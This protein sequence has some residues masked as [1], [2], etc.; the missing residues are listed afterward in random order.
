MTAF[1]FPSIDSPNRKRLM[2][3][4]DRCTHGERKIKFYV[5]PHLCDKSRPY[6]R[7]QNQMIW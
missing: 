7:E 4:N 3:Y 5:H 2:A 6:K 1:Y